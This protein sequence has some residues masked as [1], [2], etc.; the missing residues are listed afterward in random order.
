MHI[1]RGLFPSK[2]KGIHRKSISSGQGNGAWHELSPCVFDV[3]HRQVKEGLCHSLLNKNRGNLFGPNTV[4]ILENK[5][6][7]SLPSSLEFEARLGFLRSCSGLLLFDDCLVMPAILSSHAE[8]LWKFSPALPKN[9]F[10]SITDYV[11]NSVYSARVGT[12]L[13]IRD[14][15][16]NLKVR[17]KDSSRNELQVLPNVDTIDMLYENKLRVSYCS[18]DGRALC[19]LRKHKPADSPKLRGLYERIG[20][21]VDT[22]ELPDPLICLIPNTKI[23][24][25]FAALEEEYLPLSQVMEEIEKGAQR[26][27]SVRHKK[28]TSVMIGKLWRLDLKRVACWTIDGSTSRKSP[29]WFLEN[30]PLN[31]KVSPSAPRA[32]VTYEV[33]LEMSSLKAENLFSQDLRKRNHSCGL[34]DFVESYVHNAQL[35]AMI[36]QEYTFGED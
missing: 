7:G 11:K 36:A 13:H 1:H 26:L 18:K 30:S 27:K 4:K 12:P 2:L 23:V 5:H 33:E 19:A 29:R 34:G 14:S 8:P 28:C 3:I 35:L 24:I 16:K 15:M 32:N 9:A 31:G 25:R 22:P 6:A 20:G 10:Q 21:K 17:R